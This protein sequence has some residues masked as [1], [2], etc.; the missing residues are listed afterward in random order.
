M[1]DYFVLDNL[2]AD[3]KQAFGIAGEPAQQEQEPVQEPAGQEQ[4]PPANVELDQTKQEEP[5]QQ[6]PQNGTLNQYNEFGRAFAEENIFTG[7]SE[8]DLNAIDSAEAF[9]SAMDK[10]VQSRLTKVQQLVYNAMNAGV[11]P[12]KAGQMAKDIEL[13][14]SISDETLEDETKNGE[15]W[16]KQLM[17]TYY[18]RMGMSQERAN[19]LISRSFND[20]HDIEDAKEA[21]ESLKA[22]L[23]KDYDNELQAQKAEQEKYQND[24]KIFYQNAAKSVHETSSIFGV[25]L[26]ENSRKNIYDFAFNQIQDPQT[27]EYTTPLNKFANENPIEFGI[28]VGSLYEITN[29]FKDLGKFTALAERKAQSKG[30]SRL[31][32]LL[33]QNSSN[34]GDG[35]LRFAQSTGDN[36]S[37]DDLKDIAGKDVR[38]DL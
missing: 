19:T 3:Q 8:D 25:N 20:G 10:E 36:G 6:E 29:G 2:D 24:M 22:I 11:E 35:G 23:Q 18:S 33:Q 26:S 21:R 14:D 13:I 32:N 31:A 34:A 16:R 17:M 27:G 12:T 1:E 15:E 30:A 28:I 4:E 38:L 9:L 7:L 37:I 5:E